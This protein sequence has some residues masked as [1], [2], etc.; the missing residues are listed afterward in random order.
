MAKRNFIPLVPSGTINADASVAQL[1]QDVLAMDAKVGELAEDIGDTEQEINQLKSAISEAYVT[2]EMFGAKGD[3]TTADGDAVQAALNSGVLVIAS[4]TYNI[5][6][7]TPY[8]AGYFINIPDGAHIIGGTFKFPDNGAT[9]TLSTGRNAFCGNKFTLDGCTFDMNGTNNIPS[10]GATTTMY[11][12]FID[13]C[14]GVTI[15][16]CRFINSAGRDYVFAKTGKSFRMENCTFKNGGTNISGSSATK[17]ND[18]SYI[19]ISTDDTVISGC[20]VETP[21][22]DPFTYCGGFEIHGN[23]SVVEN[24]IINKC[25]PAIYVAQ[26]WNE[27][28][29]SHV[30]ILNNAFI[31]CQGGVSLFNNITLDDIEVSGN[32]ISLKP[33]VSSVAQAMYGIGSGTDDTLS[34]IVYEKNIIVRDTSSPNGCS[35]ISFTN[36]TNIRVKDNVI[37]NVDNPIVISGSAD[38]KE[39]VVTGNTITAS[40]FNSSTGQYAIKRNTT[41]AKI[42][43]ATITENEIVNY[44]GLINSVN[45]ITDFLILDRI[46]NT[47]GLFEKSKNLIPSEIKTATVNGVGVTNDHGLI[48]LKGTGSSSGGRLTPISSYFKLPAGTY[49]LS[50]K[51]IKGPTE[52]FFIEVGSTIKAQLS[53]SPTGA[54]TTFTLTEDTA[55]LYLGVNVS[56]GEYDKQFEIQLESG[57]TATM[58]MQSGY[59]TAV[60]LVARAAIAAL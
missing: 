39:V 55:S 53:S 28:N 37:T 14:A 40:S 5:S 42:A 45:A 23:N 10:E 17:Q 24:C 38:N 43:M 58:F 9:S 60:D 26:H 52:Q 4:G 36:V 1:E 49:T 41:T 34:N 21:D 35:G 2:P 30:K 13:A 18:F 22:A 6:R 16:N 8:S 48:T 57:D 59:Y 29:T 32:Y 44:Q 51:D 7:D 31:Q 47:D 54:S 33:V 19:Y 11:A 56:A 25:L 27:S 15:K 20:T 46:V 12:I 50:A 3:G